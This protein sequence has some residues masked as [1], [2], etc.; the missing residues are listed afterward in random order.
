[1]ATPEN[2]QRRGRIDATPRT[3]GSADVNPQRH[4]AR[5]LPRGAVC[6][7]RAAVA[8]GTALATQ[9][10]PDAEILA[11]LRKSEAFSASVR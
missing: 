3:C 11:I 1:M 2:E 5:A 6:A 4:A 8:A 10:L 9:M 7:A